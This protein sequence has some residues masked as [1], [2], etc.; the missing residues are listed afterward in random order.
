MT[1]EDRDADGDLRI[2]RAFEP[3]VRLT[4]GEY[5]VPT[6]VEGYV[7]RATLWRLDADGSVVKAAEPGDLDLDSLARL[8]RQ[9]DGPGYSLSGA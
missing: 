4:Q 8:G 2:L 6:S 1:A 7:R 9:L 5:F 3:V